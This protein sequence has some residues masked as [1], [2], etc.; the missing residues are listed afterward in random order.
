MKKYKIGFIGCGNMASAIIKGL[1]EN[2][3]VTPARIFVSDISREATAK[4]VDA[5]HVQ[6]SESTVIAKAADILF[7][8]V[9]PQFYESVIAEIREAVTQDKII[10]T[11]APGKTLA[12]L[13]ERFGKVVKLA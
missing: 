5:F 6:A 13:R 4:A 7:L 11:I 12:W 3:G 8:S 9:K 10:I 1:I 2:A